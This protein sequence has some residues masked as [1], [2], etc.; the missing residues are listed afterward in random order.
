VNELLKGGYKYIGDVDSMMN[1]AS[2][3]FRLY[4]REQPPATKARKYAGVGVVRGSAN[5]ASDEYLKI[6]VA[7]NYGNLTFDKDFQ[8]AQAA[9]GKYRYLLK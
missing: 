2:E 4:E 7:R 9:Y 8:T 6:Y 5:I 1:S 3:A